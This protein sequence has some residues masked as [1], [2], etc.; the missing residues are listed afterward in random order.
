MLVNLERPYKE[1][2]NDIRGGRQQVLP[3]ERLVSHSFLETWIYD[4]VKF[5]KLS[6]VQMPL[7]HLLQ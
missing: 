4:G 7:F 2:I 1:E 5:E 3:S 6:I